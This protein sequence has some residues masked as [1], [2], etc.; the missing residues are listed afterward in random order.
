MKIL[1][2]YDNSY[3]MNAKVITTFLEN[4]KNSITFE[5]LCSIHSE[6]LSTKHLRIIIEVL[7]YITNKRKY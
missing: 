1:S 2:D 5:K 6:I 3:F 7:R 4:V